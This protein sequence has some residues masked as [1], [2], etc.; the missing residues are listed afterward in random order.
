MNK[1]IDITNV[2]LHT[3]RLTL[4]EWETDDLDDLYEY[5]RDEDVGPMAGW[6]PH[7][8]KKESED[9]L[10]RFILGKKTFAI[11]FEGKV[12]GSFGIEKYDEI[13]LPELK[14]LS[15][16]EIGFVLSKDYWGRGLMTEAA[17]EVI[18]YL[19]EKEALDAI[20]CT[21]F[22]QNRRSARVQEKCGFEY[23]RKSTFNTAAETVE[24]SIT[25][26]LR[27][28]DYLNFTKEAKKDIRKSLL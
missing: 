13:L 25:N 4:R 18:K 9:I 20:V 7:K 26:I 1:P 27:R 2:I 11:V 14:E 19:F 21:H 17:K 22:V 24:N 16:R 28:E 8:N 23:V 15:C 10:N 6:L 5:A 12:I 3:D